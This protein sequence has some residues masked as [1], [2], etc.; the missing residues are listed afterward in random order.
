[1]LL[2]CGIG[3]NCNGH[4]LELVDKGLQLG[5]ILL[6]TGC[7]LRSTIRSVGIGHYSVMPQQAATSSSL[8]VRVSAERCVQFTSARVFA[9]R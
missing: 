8:N 7:P 2:V 5:L 9:I 3:F 4:R 1:M 6:S